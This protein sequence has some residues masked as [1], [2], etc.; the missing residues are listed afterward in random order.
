MTEK[1][2]SMST[3]HPS[4]R[5]RSSSELATS[6][7]Q[8]FSSSSNTEEDKSSTDSDVAEES[9]PM[10]KNIK[11]QNLQPSWCQKCPCQQGKHQMFFKTWL[12]KE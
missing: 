1:V 10:K 5:P 12:K 3:I 2:A 8:E 9:P 6:Q 11:Q 7:V 4:K